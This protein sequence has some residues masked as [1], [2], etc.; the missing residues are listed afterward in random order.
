[1]VVKYL[2]K[3]KLITVTIIVYATIDGQ[4]ITDLKINFEAHKSSDTK[5]LSTL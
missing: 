3:L 1:M 2:R 5:I 4:L